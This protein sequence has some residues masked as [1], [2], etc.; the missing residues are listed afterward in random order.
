MCIDESMF[1]FSV[2]EKTFDSRIL[3]Y[4]YTLNLIATEGVS[5][6]RFG[7]SEIKMLSESFSIGF[8]PFSL[9]LQDALRNVATST[10]PGLLIGF[11]PVFKN[12]QW[13]NMWKRLFEPTRDYFSEIKEF[14]NT[15]VSRPPCFNELKQEAVDGW[16]KVWDN[17][18]VLV[19]TGKGGRFDL[20]QDFFGNAKEVD[21]LYGPAV[22][23]FSQ[24][25]ELKTEVLNARSYDLYLL[26]LGPAA[27]V[28]AADLHSMG[29][30]ALDVGHLSASYAFFRGDGL[31]P[32]KIEMIRES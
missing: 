32:E 13:S 20:Y 11:P 17:K 2:I 8:Q 29:R 22:D 6:A 16:R 5:L 19:V 10:N 30:K 24:L 9:K 25:D 7:D 28:L 4:R 18:S 12:E 14:G 31:Y 1:D 26:S 23:A 21:I 3:S 27:T 15:A